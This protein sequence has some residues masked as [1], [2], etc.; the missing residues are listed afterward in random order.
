MVDVGSGPGLT[1]IASIPLA[2]PAAGLSGTAPV[3]RYYVR[4]RAVESCGPGPASNEIVVDVPSGCA[5][6]AAPGMLTAS[7][8]GRYV[9]LAWGAAGSAASYV[10]EVGSASGAAN[11][12]NLD[13]GSSLSIGGQASPATYYVRV[14]GRGACGQLGPAS[15][16][17]VVAVP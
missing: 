3:G 12:L 17:V 16:E 9:S 8:S 13:V 14:R 15:N 5:V 1:D 4:A 2:A 7:R 11:L 10:L 6:P